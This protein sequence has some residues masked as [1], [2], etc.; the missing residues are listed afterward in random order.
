MKLRSARRDA[1]PAGKDLLRTWSLVWIWVLPAALI[2]F[3]INAYLAKLLSFDQ[4]GAILTAATAWI[5]IGCF[6]NA[7][8]CGRTHCTID[9]ILL[10]LLSV[11]G[12]L[13]LAGVIAIRWQFY[14]QIL[15]VI[16]VVSFVPECCGAMY[17]RRG[18][19]SAGR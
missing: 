8:R 6:A 18:P 11:C 7:R 4:A 13:N 2:I 14:V 5:G 3:A 15:I 9:G 19:R 12:L 1:G 16:V 17:L 10:P